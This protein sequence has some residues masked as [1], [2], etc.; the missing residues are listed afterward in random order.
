MRD[1]SVDGFVPSCSCGCGRSSTSTFQMR[2]ISH[3][4]QADVTHPHPTKGRAQGHRSCIDDRVLNSARRATAAPPVSKQGSPDLPSRR[5]LPSGFSPTRQ[6]VE[7]AVRIIRAKYPRAN[8]CVK[9]AGN[10]RILC[11]ARHQLRPIFGSFCLSM[12]KRRESAYLNS[13][14]RLRHQ[15][16][17]FCRCQLPPSKASWKPLIGRQNLFS[18]SAPDLRLRSG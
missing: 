7:E 9:T 16:P 15:L 17:A 13:P 3:V 4:D 1:Q 18:I 10:W 12:S 2:L 5:V 14:S 8:D 6:R 11:R